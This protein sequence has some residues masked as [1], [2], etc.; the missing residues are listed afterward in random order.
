MP[1]SSKFCTTKKNAH[2]RA[3]KHHECAFGSWWIAAECPKSSWVFGLSSSKNAWSHVRFFVVCTLLAASACS[4][5]TA[6]YLQ[7][8]ES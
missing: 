4:P 6:R 2:R 3:K 7:G 1:F 8:F 5:L